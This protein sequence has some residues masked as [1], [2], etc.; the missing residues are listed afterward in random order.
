M[1]HFSFEENI[2]VDQFNITTMNA[3]IINATFDEW[4]KHRTNISRKKP[5]EA[6]CIEMM[7]CDVIL[8]LVNLGRLFEYKPFI[9]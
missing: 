1:I 8:T 2:G 9:S 4:S 3:R 7:N 5:T 6:K